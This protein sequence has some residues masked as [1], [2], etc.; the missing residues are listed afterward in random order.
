[1]GGGKRGGAGR[2]KSEAV[3]EG[4]MGLRVGVKRSGWQ[5]KRWGDES[6]KEKTAGRCEAKRR[7]EWMVNSGRIV[8]TQLYDSLTEQV[9]GMNGL[10]TNAS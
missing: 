1:M 6:R 9:A 10:P 2:G 4:E 8:T 5:R 7:I 3:S